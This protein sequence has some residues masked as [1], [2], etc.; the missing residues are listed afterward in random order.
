V[1]TVAEI[2]LASTLRIAVLRLSRRLRAERTD[3]TLSASQL[4]ALAALSQHGPL[5]LGDLAAHERVRPPSMTR[6]VGH[7]E[8]RGLAIRVP[9][10]TDRRQVLVE[11]SRAGKELLRADRRRRDAWLAVKLKGL[12]SEERA[13]LLAAAPILDRLAQE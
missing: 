13:L 11:I 2:E 10:P 9:D 3:E 4:S 5:T 1:R 8:D 7:L 12:S 6:I